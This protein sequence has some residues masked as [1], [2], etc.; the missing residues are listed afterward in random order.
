MPASRLQQFDNC[1]PVDPDPFQF[2]RKTGNKR[3]GGQPGGPGTQWPHDERMVGQIARLDRRSHRGQIVKGATRIW[4]Q[5]PSIVEV[6]FESFDCPKRNATS[7]PSTIRSC[8]S[9]AIRKSTCKAGCALI[10]RPI[11]G[12][13][14]RTPKLVDKATRR[15][16]R[17][18]VAPRAA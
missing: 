11:R 10:N 12:I 5:R 3:A 13:A 2:V 18:S 14:P 8:R 15:W 7:T 17:S 1:E 6:A 4:A 16:P 9:S